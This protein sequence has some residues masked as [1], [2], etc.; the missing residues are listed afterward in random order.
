[1]YN[2][3]FFKPIL[4]ALSVLFFVSCDK[5]YNE[6]GG[7][8]IGQNHF[9]LA[10]DSLSTVQSTWAK[11]GAV[12]SN[13]LD[14]NPLGVL[15]NNAFG[16]TTSRF[17]TQVQLVSVSPVIDV[18]LEQAIESVTLYVPYFTKAN[19]TTNA[20]TGAHT[21]ELDSIYGEKT[22]KL[23]LKIYENKYLL[24]DKNTEAG[25]PLLDPSYPQFYYTNQNSDFNS[26]KDKLLYTND[27]FVFSENEYSVVTPAVVGVSAE[28]T[29]YTPPGMK[30]E[31]N[32]TFFKNLLFSAGSSTNLS[33]NALFEQYFKGLYF[34]IE[35]ADAKGVMAMLNFKKGTIVVK[36]KEKALATDLAVSVDKS[37]TLN[38][39]GNTVSLQSNDF[40]S[41]G[42]AYN[43]NP[44]ADRIYLRGGEG[45][46]GKI[47][48]FNSA[49]DVV[50][51]NRTTKKIEA[52]SNQIPDELDYIKE[53]GWLIN[54]ASLTFY[55]DQPA[56]A[57]VT[58]PNRIFLYDINNKRPLVDYFYDNTSG[59]SANYTKQI[60]GGIIQKDASERGLKYKIRV[61]NYIRNLVNNDSTNVKLGLSVSQAISN[62]TYLKKYNS[63]AYSV[64][65]GLT[66]LQKNAYFLPASSVMNPLGTILYGSGANVPDDK[67][68]K[69]KIYYTKPN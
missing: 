6:I 41:T 66:A 15:D 69:L 17:A 39:T 20:T 23:K 1:M 2:K 11:T 12:A 53:K 43:S 30:I 42:S 60:Y 19:F 33:N 21:Y 58:E 35:K 3:F 64:W 40:S 54:E 34:D 38:L 62:T 55:V 44:I 10:Q 28:T 59:N 65:K 4:L 61:T 16:Q 7:S 45:S 31:L 13:N 49:V 67:R 48:L 29:T 57:G 18:T 63:P 5:D 22:A 27:A 68:V 52:G 8:L 14:I 26:N 56:M 46:V 37:I 32:T 50:T 24:G 51:Y 9:D 47:E 25:A 36:Y